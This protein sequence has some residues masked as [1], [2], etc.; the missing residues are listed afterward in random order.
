MLKIRV[1]KT[2]SFQG[3]LSQEVTYI[4]QQYVPIPENLPEDEKKFENKVVLLSWA[5]GAKK[6]QQVVLTSNF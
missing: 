4:K 5:S 2:K 1:A 6:H 3:Q